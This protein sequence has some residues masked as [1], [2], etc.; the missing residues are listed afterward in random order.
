MNFECVGKIDVAP[1]LVALDGVSWTEE[2]WR[3]HMPFSPHRDTDTITLRGPLSVRPRAIIESLEVVD[4]PL[5]ECEPIRSAVWGIA[6]LAHKAPARAML[7]LLHP[8]GKVDQHV[9]DGRYAYLTDRYHVAVQTN[10]EAW[11]QVEGE[12]RSLPLGGVWFFEKH[13]PHSAGND[14][15][16]NRIHL[17]VDVWRT[18]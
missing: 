6:S 14:G 12:R 3:R 7:C 13:K 17:I 2:P 10:D 16:T 8:G 1:I 18:A 4:R 11:L 9:D 15:E 5:M